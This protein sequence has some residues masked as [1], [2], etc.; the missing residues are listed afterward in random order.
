MAPGVVVLVLGVWRHSNN[1][2]APPTHQL[3]RYNP[4]TQHQHQHRI[5]ATTQQPQRNTTAIVTP[6]RQ[7]NNTTTTPQQP[8]QH[9][10]PLP[11]PPTTPHHTHNTQHTGHDEE[12]EGIGW[13]RRGKAGKQEG[14]KR[15][16]NRGTRRTRRRMRI[17]GAGGGG[18]GGGPINYDQECWVWHCC[19][20][21]VVWGFS[22]VWSC[23][24]SWMTNRSSFSS[25]EIYRQLFSSVGEHHDSL[26][27]FSWFPSR[28]CL[29]P[30][31]AEF[32][33]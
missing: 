20:L 7:P 2:T 30:S 14:R 17:G 4:T 23:C 18:G 1:T 26:A 27:F 16:K 22:V 9:R 31:R 5:N 6:S 33:K 10:P 28:F 32:P 11:S 13:G 25:V 21:R 29:V 3:Q 8:Q 19:E 24:G 12:E 15:T